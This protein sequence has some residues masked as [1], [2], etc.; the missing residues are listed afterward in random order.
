MQKIEAAS[1]RICHKPATWK[2]T[3]GRLV[4]VENCVNVCRT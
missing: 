4:N 1:R 2:K 3:E